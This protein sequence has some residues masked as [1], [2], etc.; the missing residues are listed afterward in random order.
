MSHGIFSYPPVPVGSARKV[1]E[2]RADPYVSM[3]SFTYSR[4]SLRL[5]VPAPHLGVHTN[6]HDLVLAHACLFTQHRL[7]GRKAICGQVLSMQ[8]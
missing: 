2:T 5:H 1:T 4:Q 3:Q 8:F 7:S 6:N